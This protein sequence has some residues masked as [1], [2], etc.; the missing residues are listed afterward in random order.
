MDMVEV[1]GEGVMDAMEAATDEVM[2]G[3]AAAMEEAMAVAM[4]EAMDEAMEE[5]MAVAMVVVMATED[6]DMVAKR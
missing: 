6:M 5:A 3:T 2:V 1:M 4:E